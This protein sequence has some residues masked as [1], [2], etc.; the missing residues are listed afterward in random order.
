MAL[1]TQAQFD[2]SIR[3]LNE[4]LKTELSTMF[5]ALLVLEANAAAST[6]AIGALPG[7]ATP[8]FFLQTGQLALHYDASL[9]LIGSDLH[10]V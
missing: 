5:A 6:A 7:F 3:E 10:V 9:T 4:P 1:R 8:P 2:T